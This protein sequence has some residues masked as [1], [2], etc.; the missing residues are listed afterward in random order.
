M[1]KNE[2][3]TDYLSLSFSFLPKNSYKPKQPVH[4]N[5]PRHPETFYEHFFRKKY[6][7][8]KKKQ[9]T[10]IKPCL[11]K[12]K[13]NLTCNSHIQKNKNLNKQFLQQCNSSLSLSSSTKQRQENNRQKNKIKLNIFLSPLQSSAYNNFRDLNLPKF[14]YEVARRKG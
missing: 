14:F 8:K 2:Q 6:L 11:K 7:I 9:K 13:T 4:N 1:K 10:P 5:P 12:Y 3:F